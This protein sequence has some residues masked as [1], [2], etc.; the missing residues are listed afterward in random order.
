MLPIPF[1]ID[2]EIDDQPIGLNQFLMN[3]K[4]LEST[5]D[6]NHGIGRDWMNSEFKYPISYVNQHHSRP[7]FKEAS[8]NKAESNTWWIPKYKL[9]DSQASNIDLNEWKHDE[10]K[11]YEESSDQS[12]MHDGDM[13]SDKSSKE[14]W[15]PE[16]FKTEPIPKT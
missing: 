3:V 5:P 8:R 10:Q 1:K 13:S 11:E 6:P 15:Q 4:A 2:D 14:I 7:Y 12:Y 9:D 16:K